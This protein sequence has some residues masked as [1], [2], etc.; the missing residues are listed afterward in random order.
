MQKH[1]LLNLL[2]FFEYF[3]LNLREFGLK[4]AKS[5]TI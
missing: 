2:K 1:I 4:F 3:T 5:V